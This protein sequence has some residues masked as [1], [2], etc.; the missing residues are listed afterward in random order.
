LTLS[1]ALIDLSK[2]TFAHGHA[3][4]AL[5]RVRSLNDLY[6]ASPINKIDFRV[7]ESVKDYYY[8]ICENA[9]AV[10][11]GTMCNSN[12]PQRAYFDFNG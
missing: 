9:T 12:N 3:Y 6:L 11:S 1:K 7:S 10:D 8:K 4:V 2:G 5:S